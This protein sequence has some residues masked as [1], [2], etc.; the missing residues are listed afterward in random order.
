MPG[1]V[2]TD[3]PSGE[4]VA[5]PSITSRPVVWS[6]DRKFS[7]VPGAASNTFGNVIVAGA[8]RAVTPSA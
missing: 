3:L 4:T 2:T 8:D 7:F 6:N 1:S 5:V